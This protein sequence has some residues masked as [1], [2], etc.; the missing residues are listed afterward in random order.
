MMQSQNNVTGS[1]NTIPNTFLLDIA[2]SL[3]RK[4][5][6]V[7]C[8]CILQCVSMNR[9]LKLYQLVRLLGLN[10]YQVKRRVNELTSKGFL[11]MK[12]GIVTITDDGRKLCDALANII[13][14]LHN[15]DIK[16]DNK[17]PAFIG[18]DALWLN[19]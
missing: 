4:P 17:R 8:Y 14:L 3:K 6:Y 13:L 1:N 9:G 2:L 5:I 19:R 10:Y 12:G 7:Q 18:L 11:R 15:T 16:D